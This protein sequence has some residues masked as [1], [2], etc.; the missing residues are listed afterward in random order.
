MKVYPVMDKTK[1]KCSTCRYK[2]ECLAKHH[3]PENYGNDCK[4]YKEMD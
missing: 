4:K 2:Y 3:I 1:V